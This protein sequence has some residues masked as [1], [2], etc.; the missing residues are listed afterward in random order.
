VH[1]HIK[2]TSF[3]LV[4]LLLAFKGFTAEH[5]KTSFSIN[6]IPSDFGMIF[7]SSLPSDTL[8]ILKSDFITQLTFY[9]SDSTVFSLKENM[10]KWVSPQT[11]GIYEIIVKADLQTYVLKLFVMKPLDEI[12]KNS[13]HFI[14]GDYPSK[15]YKNMRQYAIPDGMIEVTE[16]NQETYLSEHFQVKDFLTKQQSGFPKYVIISPKLIYKLELIIQK[17]EANGVEVENLHVMSGYRTPHYNGSIGN[18]RNSRHIYGDAADIF[19]DNDNNQLM[20]DVN[21]DGK[22]TIEDARFLGA[23]ADKIDNDPKHS[24]LKGGIGVYNG[25]G[26]HGVFVHIDTRGNI[27]RW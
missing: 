1:M 27:I 12:K 18:G 21:K 19:L 3:I 24:W 10:L 17:M 5:P 26:S 6:G 23:I 11:P 4:I 7:I 13:P 20:D 22:L 2:Y 25:N 15:S 14:V 16:A 9:S 8:T